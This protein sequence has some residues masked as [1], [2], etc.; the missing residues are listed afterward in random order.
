[1]ALKLISVTAV[2]VLNVI[3]FYGDNALGIKTSLKQ[4]HHSEEKTILL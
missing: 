3:S 2:M 4:H 1:M